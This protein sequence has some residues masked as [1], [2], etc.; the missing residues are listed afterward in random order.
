MKWFL[1]LMVLIGD[2]LVVQKK[3][4][5]FLIWI[6]V[7]GYFTFNNLFECDYAQAAVFGLYVIMGFYGLSAWKSGG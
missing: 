3:R 1:V 5:G 7:D 2:Y 4:S 6:L